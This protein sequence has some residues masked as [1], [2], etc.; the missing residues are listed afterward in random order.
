ME[1]NVNDIFEKL[2]KEFKFVYNTTEAKKPLEEDWG[3]GDDAYAWVL[4]PHKELE[5]YVKKAIEASNKIHVIMLLPVN[6]DEDWWHKYCTQGTIFY[7]KGPV[8]YKKN[9]AAIPSA[10]IML[11][12]GIP[13]HTALHVELREVD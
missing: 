1:H 11:G 10:I 12:K 4:P 8:K 2:N 7:I 6:P 3:E 5:Q 13:K 9:R